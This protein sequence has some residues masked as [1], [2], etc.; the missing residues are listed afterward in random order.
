[1]LRGGR[2]GSVLRALDEIVSWS[3]LRRREKVWKKRTDVCFVI[4]PWCESGGVEYGFAG[5]IGEARYA[6]FFGGW[7]FIR[8]TGNR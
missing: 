4:W 6:S 3:L 1:M 8:G 5:E 7:K 2:R